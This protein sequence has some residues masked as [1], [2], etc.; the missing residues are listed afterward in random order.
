[1][2]HNHPSGDPTPSRADIDLTKHLKSSLLP[3][4]IHVLDH[5][6]IGKKGYFSF[7]E[8]GMMGE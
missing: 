7:R 1:M 8:Q 4:N 3:F 5:F 6:I 2:V